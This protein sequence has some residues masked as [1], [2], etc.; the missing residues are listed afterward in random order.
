MVG[1]IL[2]RDSQIK[3]IIEGYTEGRKTRGTFFREHG[4]SKARCL[5]KKLQ[6]H[7]TIGVRQSKRKTV[8]NQS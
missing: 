7:S 8:A 3:S 4:A 2:G 1:Y 6:G 5:Q